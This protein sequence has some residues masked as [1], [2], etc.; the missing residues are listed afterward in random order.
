MTEETEKF[1]T[2]LL[3]PVDVP[4][5][6]HMIEADIAKA[7]S[8]GIGEMSAFDICKDAI[9]GTV[10]IWITLNQ[11]N[12]I[13]CTTTLRFLTYQS[14]KTCQIITNTTNGVSL[15]QIEHDHRLFEDFAKENGCSHLQVWG[16]KGWQRRLQSL[17]SRQG[18]KYETQYYVFD[19][20]I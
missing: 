18:N 2:F 4:I 11:N 9:N 17:S 12:K 15:K 8:H 16:R 20:E 5:L 10:F 7:L 6:W 19:M 13:V 1:R 14:K 3:S